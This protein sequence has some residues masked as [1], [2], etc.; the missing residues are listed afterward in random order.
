M[1]LPVFSLLL[2]VFSSSTLFV[3][4]RTLCSLQN[5]ISTSRGQDSGRRGGECIPT[6]QIT[7]DEYDP[8]IV[9]YYARETMPNIQKVFVR[10]IKEDDIDDIERELYICRKF[11]ERSVS[12]ETWGNE[13]YFCLL[14]NRTIV[15]KGMLRSE[16][17]GKF[18]FDLQNELYKSPS[19]IYHR[20][21]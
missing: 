4:Y 15:Y 20:G 19:A 16:V 8:P 3:S 7:E 5:S 2:L 14:S 11:I 12:S 10:I 13:L 9:G 17:L 6:G 21:V 18:Y 1:F